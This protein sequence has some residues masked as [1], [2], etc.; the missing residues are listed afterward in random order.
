M[1]ETYRQEFDHNQCCDCCGSCYSHNSNRKLHL[2]N[3]EAVMLCVE[4]V[5]VQFDE[6]WICV[7]FWRC[8]P[9]YILKMFEMSSVWY[10]TSSWT[11]IFVTAELYRVPSL[12]CIILINVICYACPFHLIMLLA[13]AAFVCLCKPGD[14][15]DLEIVLNKLF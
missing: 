3:T 11:N 9:L 12:S 2:H 15:Q 7:L 8:I 5:F 1:F 10:C 6:N 13:F 14:L 4:W